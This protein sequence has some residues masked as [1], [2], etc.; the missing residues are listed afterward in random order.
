M[1]KKTELPHDW[2][3]KNYHREIE[4]NEKALI[5]EA[6]RFRDSALA[7]GRKYVDWDRAFNSWLRS[8][9]RAQTPAYTATSRTAER[10][11]RNANTIRDALGGERRP[12]PTFTPRV[13]RSE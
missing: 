6:D 7:H 12:Y 13:D 10:D 9:Y 8:P 3:P 4:P 2:Q 11:Q 5:Q 1:A